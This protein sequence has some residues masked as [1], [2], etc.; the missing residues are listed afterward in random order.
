MK[1]P[2]VQKQLARIK[3]RGWQEK[4]EVMMAGAG[5]GGKS[6]ARGVGEGTEKRTS[7]RKTA[8]PP[9]LRGE[10]K[11][12]VCCECLSA[13]VQGAGGSIT[14][15]VPIA[16]TTMMVGRNTHCCCYRR[17]CT[18]L[19]RITVGW[20]EVWGASRIRGKGWNGGKWATFSKR[21]NP[22]KIKR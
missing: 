11:R 1:L 7:C 14:L 18:R 4:T 9:R 20:E 19:V 22:L 15:A 17:R 12:R 10:R 16:T 3:R 5:A 21:K 2:W 13:M 8:L 6:R